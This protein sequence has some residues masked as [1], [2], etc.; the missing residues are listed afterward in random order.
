MKNNINQK[1]FIVPVLLGVL[2]LL[3]I[4]G[5]SYV[6][7]NKKV[8]APVVVNENENVDMV[9][10][11]IDKKVEA[12]VVVNKK[13]KTDIYSQ[14]DLKKFETKEYTFLAPKEWNE[15]S[16]E[17][18]GCKN[19]NISKEGSENKA[20]QSIIIYPKS[21][22]NSAILNIHGY[23]DEQIEKNGFYILSV[24]DNEKGNYSSEE[25]KAKEVYKKVVETFTLNQK[26]MTVKLY[27]PNNVFNPK[28]L[29][30]SLVYP[31]ERIIPYTEGVAKATLE[32]LI[33]GPTVEEIKNGYFSSI[34]KGTKANSV[35]MIGSTL[36]ID[37]NEIAASGG[38]SCGQLAKGS[39]LMET[40]GQFSTV[41]EIK[42]TINGK[43][44]TED[45]FQP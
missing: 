23:A 22:F 16:T 2:V 7:K 29:D 24:Y 20:G 34:L 8:I 40:L 19:F 39:S 10:K 11:D 6:Y 25:L 3:A 4:G 45:L 14:G 35:K 12:P 41:K 17:I 44:N 31:V 26:T 18:L 21:C 27:F 5:G 30:C 43:G 37:F 42:M 15:G 9:K 32:E 33:K 1:G 13:E 28:A 36:V 38:G